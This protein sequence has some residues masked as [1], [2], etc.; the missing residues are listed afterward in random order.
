M[1]YTGNGVGPSHLAGKILSSLCLDQEDE[2]TDLPMVNWR[3][4]RYPPQP[5]RSIGARVI[6]AAVVRKD[7]Q[8]EE[9]GEAGIVT[10]AV[11][12]LP[13]RFGYKLPPE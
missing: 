5:F 13:G 6:N 4:R 10:N 2:W 7:R 11:A 1:G 9:R 3:P 12:R 8:E